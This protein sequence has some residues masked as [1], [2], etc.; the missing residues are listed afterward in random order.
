MFLG[1][2]RG[3]SLESEHLV[4]QKTLSAQQGRALCRGSACAPSLFSLCSSTLCLS[5]A[6]PPP[7]W[8]PTAFFLCSVSEL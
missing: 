6:V 4:G 1:V 7:D 2:Y 8:H 3:L 5:A